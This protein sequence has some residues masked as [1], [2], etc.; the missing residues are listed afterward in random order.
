MSEVK[1]DSTTTQQLA[2]IL[3]LSP[4]KTRKVREVIIKSC[5]VVGNISIA[6]A[7]WTYNTLNTK[8]SKMNQLKNFKLTNTLK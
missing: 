4:E 1:G 3:F 7:M 5:G 2:K 8:I 6:D